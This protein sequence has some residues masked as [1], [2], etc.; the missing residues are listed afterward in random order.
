MRMNSDA[1]DVSQCGSACFIYTV[2]DN[3]VI[4]LHYL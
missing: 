1:S 4:N 3:K 2:R